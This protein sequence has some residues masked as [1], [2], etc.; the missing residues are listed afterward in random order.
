LANRSNALTSGYSILSLVDNRYWLI[1]GSLHY[2]GAPQQTAIS[3]DMSPAVE[4]ILV[5][6][7]PFYAPACK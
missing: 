4:T 3:S 6:M 2:P 5:V 7:W 1:I